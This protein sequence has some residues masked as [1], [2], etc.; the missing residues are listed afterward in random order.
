MHNLRCHI[1]WLTRNHTLDVIGSDIVV[2]AY[3]HV[4]GLGIYEEIAVINILIAES[5]EMQVYERVHHI[6]GSVEAYDIRFEDCFGLAGRGGKR[7]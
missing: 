1:A 5:L 7:H 4:A 2:V 3:Q 6:Y